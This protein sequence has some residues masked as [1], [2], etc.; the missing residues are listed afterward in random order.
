MIIIHEHPSPAA[1]GDAA[2]TSALWP[3]LLFPFPIP[4]EK[5]YSSAARL[6][7]EGNMQLFSFTY[8]VLYQIPYPVATVESRVGRSCWTHCQRLPFPSFQQS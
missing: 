7:L 5:K 4:D 2:R 1:N 6:Y 3:F 8:P